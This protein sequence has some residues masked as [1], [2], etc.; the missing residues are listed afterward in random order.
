MIR[1]ISWIAMASAFIMTAPI[2]AAPAA[3]QS[4]D[5]FF[6]AQDGLFAISEKRERTFID[7]G[8]AYVNRATYVG[9]EETDNLV[10]PFARADYKGRLFINP[11]LGAGVYWHNTDN[12]RVSTSVNYALG[13]DGD[14]TPLIGDGG[15]IDSS[16]TVTNA[17]RYYLPIAAFDAIATV[18]FTGD[19]EGARLDTLL[20]TEIKPIKGLRITPGMRATFGTA[21]WIGSLYNIDPSD[22]TGSDLPP[23]D[24]AG[25][26]AFQADGG[27]LALGA[28]TAAYY[29]LPNNFQLIGVV[30]YSALQNDAK[31]SPLS[32][33]NSGLTL[34]LGIARHF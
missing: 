9:S 6:G 28:H 2:T 30:N 12:L 25:L 16:F 22:I 27:L 8:V 4:A 14:D 29:E 1:H 20:T 24:I 33:D 17:L 13:R 5:G 10:L 3:A 34:A 31:D 23:V 7:A 15:E 32:I 11:A 21:G 19:F 18:P 26:E